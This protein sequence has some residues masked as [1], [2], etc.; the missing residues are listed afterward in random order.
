MSC[1][2]LESPTPGTKSGLSGDPKVSELS[3]CHLCPQEKMP[4]RWYEYIGKPETRPARC[5]LCDCFSLYLF[6]ASRLGKTKERKDSHLSVFL[7][8]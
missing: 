6:Q 7:A 1:E 8:E 5:V 2:D 3:I 4:C